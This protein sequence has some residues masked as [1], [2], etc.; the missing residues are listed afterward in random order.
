MK[1]ICVSLF[2]NG[3]SL[4]L[5]SRLIDGVHLET[6]SLLIMTVT[7]CILNITIKPI[8]KLLFLPFNIMTLG[9]FSLITNALVLCL[10]FEL[11]PSASYDGFVT[12]IIAGLVLAISN[13]VLNAMF[14]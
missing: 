8:L 11:I 12:C 7:F 13:T 4:Y 5:V 9:L 1:K 3:L 14:K 6:S 2:V 10:A